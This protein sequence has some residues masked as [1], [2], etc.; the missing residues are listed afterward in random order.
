[1]RPRGDGVALGMGTL[2]EG[3]EGMATCG[4][5]ALVG[6]GGFSL[7]AWGAWAYILAAKGEWELLS[8]VPDW[9]TRASAPQDLADAYC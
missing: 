4:A 2:C 6:H 1:M 3:G 8:L 5:D 7:R 9:P